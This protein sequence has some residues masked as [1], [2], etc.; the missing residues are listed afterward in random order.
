MYLVELFCLVKMMKT[1]FDYRRVSL[2]LR[3]NENVFSL[4][5][6][7]IQCRLFI[8][9]EEKKNGRLAPGYFCLLAFVHHLV[10]YNLEK[11]ECG[12]A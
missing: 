4:K 12:P 3:R 11:N 10:F 8:P 2:V 9:K 6:M 7:I 5:N 1:F